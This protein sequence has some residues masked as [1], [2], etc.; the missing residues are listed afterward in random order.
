MRKN[1]AQVL[2]DAKIDINKEYQKLLDLFNK[3]Y[4]EAVELYFIDFYFRGTCIS[5][6]EFNEK[7]GFIFHKKDFGVTIDEFIRLAEYFYNMVIALQSANAYARYQTNTQFAM[8]LILQIMEEIGYMKSEEDGFIIF[9]EKSQ[10]AIEVAELLDGQI[11]YKTI[12]YNHHSLKGNLDEKRSILLQYADLLEP[13]RKQLESLNKTL[14]TN[15]FFMF[16]NMQIR[17]NNKDPKNKSKYK[18]AVAKMSKDELEKWYDD[19]Y[20]MCLLAFLEIDNAER[21][22]RISELKKRMENN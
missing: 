15:L 7:Y 16:N 5:L 13:K 19:T 11:S 21:K 4:K 18:E 8:D 1:F 2:K 17:H 9:V 12:S 14:E 22:E 3:K 10:A 20:Q 6:N